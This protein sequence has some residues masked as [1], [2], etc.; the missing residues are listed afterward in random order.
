MTKVGTPSWLKRLDTMLETAANPLWLVPGIGL[1]ESSGDRDR[2]DQSSGIPTREQLECHHCGGETD[3]RFHT[4]ES[5]SDDT[6]SG[7]PIWKCHECGACRYGP[8]LST[9][10]PP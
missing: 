2:D 10:C 3:H 1:K 4:R 6:W 7:Q 5:L 8:S 9:R